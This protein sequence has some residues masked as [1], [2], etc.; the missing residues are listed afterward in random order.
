MK[1][2]PAWF[3]EKRAG[4]LRVLDALVDAIKA[5]GLTHSEALQVLCSLLAGIL[6]EVEI[7]EGRQARLLMQEK[8]A[9]FLAEVFEED[10]QE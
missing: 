5:E 4:Q 2:V 3:R 8:V 9:V 6:D 10:G 1:E 7:D